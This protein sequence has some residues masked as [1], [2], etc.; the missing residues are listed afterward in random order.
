M[1]LRVSR[2]VPELRD[3]GRRGVRAPQRSGRGLL[4]FYI[5]RPGRATQPTSR[6]AKTE[7]LICV[8]VGSDLAFHGTLHGGKVQCKQIDDGS[9]ALGYHTTRPSC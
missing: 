3:F 5:E 7:Y 6:P 9:T 1:S 8:G 4:S 2:T